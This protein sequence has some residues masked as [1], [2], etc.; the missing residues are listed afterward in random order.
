M[1][2][3]CV[4]VEFL[5]FGEN[6]L[7]EEITEKLSISP[8][9]KWRKGDPLKNGGSE[10]SSGWEICTDYEESL[11]INDQLNKIVSKLSIKQEQLIN[12]CNKNGMESRFC[13]AIIIENG[14]TPSVGL[15]KE[16]I[17]FAH[18]LKAEIDFDI[19]VNPY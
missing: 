2:N 18:F 13:I 9:H 7:P 3:T 15:S 4:K 6:V 8:S 11:D 19:Y 5:I 1:V 12:I 17:E 16:I 14:Q 10:E